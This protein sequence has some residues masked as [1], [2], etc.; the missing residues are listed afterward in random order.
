VISRKFDFSEAV[1][2]FETDGDGARD[3]DNCLLND[4]A[5]PADSLEVAHILPH[6]LTKTDPGSELVSLID[7]YNRC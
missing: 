1:K 5:T 7:Q 3:D 2:R 4:D 6:S